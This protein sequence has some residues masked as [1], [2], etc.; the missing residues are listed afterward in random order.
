MDIVNIPAKG[1][2][3]VTL[4]NISPYTKTGIVRTAMT[5]KRP[6]KAIG[7]IT[8]LVEARK[9]NGREIIAPTIVPKK[10][11]TWFQKVGRGFLELKNQI[12]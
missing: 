7:L 1:P 5:N 2:G 10:L 3:P 12:I 4:I 9:E 8:I 6:I 11:Y